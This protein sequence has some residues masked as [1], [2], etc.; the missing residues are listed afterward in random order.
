MFILEFP[1][2]FESLLLLSNGLLEKSLTESISILGADTEVATHL[3][4]REVTRANSLH[5]RGAG[6][7]DTLRRNGRRQILGDR[8]NINTLPVSQ[9]MQDVLNDLVEGIAKL[10][11]FSTRNGQLNGGFFRILENLPRLCASL[12]E[13]IFLQGVG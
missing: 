3:M 9:G 7:T 4:R 6:N 1:E 5:E 11:A 10:L 8:L 13:G 2:L 12:T